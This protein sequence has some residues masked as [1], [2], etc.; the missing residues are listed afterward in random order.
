MKNPPFDNKGMI[1]IRMNNM[2]IDL[3]NA[4]KLGLTEEVKSENC[5]FLIFKE[6]IKFIMG[7]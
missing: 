7:Y 2:L 3:F 5:K 4:T 6:E 1:K